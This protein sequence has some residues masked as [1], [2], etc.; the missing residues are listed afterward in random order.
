[1]NCVFLGCS[2]RSREIIPFPR[3]DFQHNKREMTSSQHYLFCIIPRM[4]LTRV[5]LIETLSYDKL[6]TYEEDND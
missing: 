3:L 6:Q 4:T 1:M 5:R 2:R